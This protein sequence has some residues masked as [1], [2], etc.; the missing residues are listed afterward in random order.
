MWIASAGVGVG[1]TQSA[2]GF[3][4]TL[5]D[6]QRALATMPFDGSQRV[7]WHF[8]PKPQRKGVQIKDMTEEQRKAAFNLLSSALSEVGYAKSRQIMELESILHE[9]EKDR[10]DG[11][12]RDAQ[13]YYFTLFGA[14]EPDT[15]WGL[16]VEGHHLSLNFVVNRGRVVAHT[17]AFLGA[18]PAEVKTDTGVGPP[19]GTRTLAKEEDLAFRLLR[20][21]D[22][23]QRKVA[24]IAEKAPREMRAAGEA[25]PPNTTPEGLSSRKM[26]EQQVETLWALVETY[27]ENMPPSI[28][29]ARRSEIN[30]AGFGHVHFAWAGASSPGI[31]HYYRVQGPTFLIEFINTQPDAQG[32]PA[33]HIHSIWRNM[34][35]DFGLSR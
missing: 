1:M 5:T 15:R 23:E 2:R 24:V 14:P 17:P 7:A 13:R 9:L 12:I 19:K 34:A 35:G 28:A 10:T 8:I 20:S 32:N 3:L 18:N 6:E 21:F 29:E 33:N 16:S 31:G 22:D 26:S 25:H 27:L 30:K 4:Q 11:P